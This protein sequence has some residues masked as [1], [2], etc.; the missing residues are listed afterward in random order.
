M[1]R[2]ESFAK[3]RELHP[4]CGVRGVPGPEGLASVAC[5]CSIGF[6]KGMVYAVSNGV[7]V[8]DKFEFVKDG[9]DQG[10]LEGVFGLVEGSANRTEF[11]SE[12]LE[13]FVEEGELVRPVVG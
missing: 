6:G 3:A 13:L 7:A 12:Q 5:G 10:G 2:E 9:R 1:F 11:L 8:R 4:A